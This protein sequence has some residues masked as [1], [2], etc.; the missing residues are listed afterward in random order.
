M[1]P[2]IADG[3]IVKV[4]GTLHGTQQG[5][6]SKLL[7]W[8]ELEA[9][10]SEAEV[11]D[12]TRLDTP[13]RTIIPETDCDAP[14]E[15]VQ[16]GALDK[17]IE[18]LGATLLQRAHKHDLIKRHLESD[19]R[20]MNKRHVMLEVQVQKG[21]LHPFQTT[22]DRFSGNDPP[23]DNSLKR[24]RDFLSVFS[25][26]RGRPKRVSR[27]FWSETVLE[28]ETSLRSLVVHSL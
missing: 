23:G 27:R 6:V 15:L 12:I 22:A 28:M 26:R 9:A 2:D 1:R 3:Q 19:L 17:G 14:R 10:P 25:G 24:H 16:D 18:S 21:L 4:C 11:E 5:G 13:P 8:H 7:E 20:A